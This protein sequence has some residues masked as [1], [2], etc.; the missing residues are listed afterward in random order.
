MSSRSPADAARRAWVPRAR[1][2]RGWVVAAL[3]FVWAGR[4]VWE[5]YA[6][7]ARH[8]RRIVD[9]LPLYLGGR[10]LRQG[11]DPTDPE[12]LRTVYEATDLRMR[13]SGF[14]SYYPQTASMLFAPLGGSEYRE[15]ARGLQLTFGAALLAGTAITAGTMCT[16]WR[17]IA[18]LALGVGVAASVRS[19]WILINIG[20]STTLLV[21]LLGVGVWVLARGRPSDDALGGVAIGVGISLKLFPLLLL[22]PALIGRRWR[23][24]AASVAVP[25]ALFAASLALYAGPWHASPLGL[26]AAWFIDTGI[27]PG[28]RQEPGAIRFLWHARTWGAGMVV[29]GLTAWTALRCRPQSIGALAALY[30]AWGG[31]V[32]AGSAMTHQGLLMLPALGWVLGWPLSGRRP[33]LGAAAVFLVLLSAAWRRVF[34]THEPDTLQW[35]PVC[36][37]VLAACAVRL[38]MELRAP[39]EPA[40]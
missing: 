20:Q 34:T 22:V 35:L 39:Q 33:W 40:A 1:V 11:M 19:S 17:R 14:L 2:V 23:L 24:V 29:L 3:L 15:I 10:A 37:A 16:G 12:V 36:Y 27:Q 18:A 28:W 5:L 26:G 21:L 6:E 13:P 9:F 32:M 4:A 38:T 8:S 31:T 30:V 25:I 7:V